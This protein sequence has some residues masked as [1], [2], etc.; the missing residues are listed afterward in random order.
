MPPK[1]RDVPGIVP[2]LNTSL[3]RDGAGG[4]MKPPTTF[5]VSIIGKKNTPGA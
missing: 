5:E 1:W 4:V 3:Y 2:L